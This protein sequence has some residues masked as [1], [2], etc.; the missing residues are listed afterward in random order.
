MRWNVSKWR[1]HAFIGMSQ[2]EIACIRWNVS[3][4]RSLAFV[5]MPLTPFA[6]KMHVKLRVEGLQCPLLPM[7]C[8]HINETTSLLASVDTQK[9]LELEGEQPAKHWFALGSS[10]GISIGTLS[11]STIPISFMFYGLSGKPLTLGWDETP[12]EAQIEGLG[13]PEVSW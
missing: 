5:E 13:E 8:W 1:S 12:V 2:M 6:Y 3:K 7:P 11:P 9:S 4:W 10:G